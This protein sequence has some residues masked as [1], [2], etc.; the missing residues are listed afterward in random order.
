M[1]GEFEPDP[2]E[3]DR[4][5]DDQEGLPW[6]GLGV[7]EILDLFLDA[8]ARWWISGGRALD[9]WFGRSIRARED[10]DVSTVRGDLEALLADLPDR[11][12]PH[13]EL[14]DGVLTFADVPAGTEVEHVWLYDT[15]EEAY[16][17]DVNVEDGTEEDWVYRRDPSVR[18][19]WDAAV[20]DVRSVP[21]AAPA[22][23][24]LWKAVSPDDGD[25]E[26]RV[27]ILPALSDEDRDWFVRAVSR[28]HPESAWAGGSGAS[29]GA[30]HRPR[31]P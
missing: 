1:A 19:P 17:L 5:R 31:T 27:A 2:L 3:D 21:T 12:V 29:D 7:T 11:I 16:V 8:D 28:V 10:A 20:L 18:L 14:D 30:T 26:D 9:H 24:L 25:D 13:A 6:R 15:L 23:A 4:D 22:I